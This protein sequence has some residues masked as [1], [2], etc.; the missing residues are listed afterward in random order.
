MTEYKVVEINRNGEK[1]TVFFN[2]YIAAKEYR[3]N[4]SEYRL[5]YKQLV[6]PHGITEWMLV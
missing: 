5:L 1:K 6:F 3:D 4:T 2:E